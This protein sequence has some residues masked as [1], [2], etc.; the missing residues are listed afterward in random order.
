MMAGYKNINP[1]TEALHPLDGALVSIYS[2]AAPGKNKN[3]TKQKKISSRDSFRKFQRSHK[4][5]MTFCVYTG[6]KKKKGHHPVY[7]NTFIFYW[8]MVHLSAMKTMFSYMA[9]HY[10]LQNTKFTVRQMWLSLSEFALHLKKI[11][12][13]RS[14]RFPRAFPLNRKHPALL[15]LKPALSPIHHF[16]PQTPWVS[17]ETNLWEAYTFTVTSL[18]GNWNW[19]E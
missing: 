4:V 19:I 15:R 18:D 10:V 12:I 7:F 14:D 9:M 8:F 11:L 16:L 6:C 1:K 17:T 5:T 3:K 2:R 13:S